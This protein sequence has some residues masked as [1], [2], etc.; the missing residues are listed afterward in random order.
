MKIRGGKRP[1]K[2]RRRNGSLYLLVGGSV[3]IALSFLVVTMSPNRVEPKADPASRI[4]TKV[5]ASHDSV[6]IPV[7]RRIVAR[8]EQLGSVPFDMVKWPKGN[9]RGRYLQNISGYEEAVALVSLPD[10]LPI[11]LDSVAHR[12]ADSNAVVERIPKGLRAI[13]VRVDAESAVEGWARS[14]SFVDVILIQKLQKDD[15][16]LEAK[17]IAEN[18][19]ILS[20]GRSTE[21]LT[22]QSSAPRAPATVTLLVS[23][24]DAL[25][26]KLADGIG[27]LTFALRGGNDSAPALTVSTNQKAMLGAA[28][29]VI[30]KKVSYKGKATGPD[31]R[32]YL[33]G[34]DSNWIKT[35]QQRAARAALTREQSNTSVSQTN[36]SKE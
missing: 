7:P 35:N 31:G 24:D 21:P 5:A 17:I 3:L 26:I 32:V 30:P 34:Q 14:G 10:H 15:L 18:V 16:G 1:K 20:A 36:D 22:G 9:L 13:T 25:K 12:G 29:T 8:G 27:K 11:S 19:Q 33:L 28:R 4:P 2:L 6:L 23:Q